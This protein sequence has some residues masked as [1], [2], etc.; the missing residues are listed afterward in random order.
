M[1][2]TIWIH[3]CLMQILLF[4]LKLKL[5]TAI[6]IHIFHLIV[7]W[8]YSFCIFSVEIFSTWKQTYFGERAMF[9]IGQDCFF[10]G[11]DLSLKF[12]NRKIQNLKSNYF[13]NLKSHLRSDCFDTRRSDSSFQDIARSKKNP[14][15]QYVLEIWKA[16]KNLVV[17][18]PADLRWLFPFSRYCHID[19]FMI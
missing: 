16:F 4:T 1:S 10:S 17:L 11:D 18:T 9:Q 13:E 6:S 14:K 19:F 7:Q 3:N 12:R 2:A 15:I 8:I 5:E